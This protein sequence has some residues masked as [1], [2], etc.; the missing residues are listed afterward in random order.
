MPGEADLVVVNW[1]TAARA[2]TLVRSLAPVVAAG[3]RLWVVDNGSSDGS[4]RALAALT[5]APRVLR[6]EVNL[7]YAGALNL[8]LRHVDRPFLVALNTD[9]E[10]DLPAL[11]RLLATCRA[12]ADVAAVGPALIDAAGRLAVGAA[13]HDLTA[14]SAAGHFLGL[15]RLAPRRVPSLYLPQAPLAQAGRPVRVDWVC[16]AAVALRRRAL[17]RVGGVPT[18]S[19]LYAEDVLLGRRLRRS[20]YRVVYEPRAVVRHEGAGSQGGDPGPRWI[21]ATLAAHE[22]PPVSRA[23][24]RAAASAGLAARA[25]LASPPALVSPAWRDRARRMARDARAAL[26]G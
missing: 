17:V 24:A 8:A 22:G 12:R 23:L 9:V 10:L 25:L 7:G 26:L 1:N 4:A 2:A 11:R 20:G 21:V 6:S 18:D 19:F 13:G 14:R 3:A 16:G 5:P 15:H